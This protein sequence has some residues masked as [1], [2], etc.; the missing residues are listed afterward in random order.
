MK[1]AFTEKSSSKKQKTLTNDGESPT[2]KRFIKKLIMPSF[3]SSITD[4]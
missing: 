2:L 1:S 3:A 4:T